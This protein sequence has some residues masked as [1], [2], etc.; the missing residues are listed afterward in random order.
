MI[1][2]TD[3]LVI[4]ETWEWLSDQSFCLSRMILPQYSGRIVQA[5]MVFIPFRT[6]LSVKLNKDNP[7]SA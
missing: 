2:K 3:G 1:F 6:N 7:Y 5:K 4:L